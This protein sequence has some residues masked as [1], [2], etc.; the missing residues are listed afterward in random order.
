MHE[1]EPMYACILAFNVKLDK[2]AKTLAEKENVQI[3]SVCFFFCFLFCSVLFCFVF[4]FFNFF[5]FQ[6]L[7]IS[8]SFFLTS[9][10]PPTRPKLSIT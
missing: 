9:P 1:H 7:F 10:P 3:F 4:V 6:I 2:D 5:F 8:L